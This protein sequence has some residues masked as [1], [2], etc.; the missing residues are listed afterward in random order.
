LKEFGRERAYYDFENMH[1]MTRYH[2]RIAAGYKTTM[3]VYQGKVLLCAEVAHKLFNI[4]S[5]YEVMQRMHREHPS[6][7]YRAACTGYLVGQTVMTMYNK[8]TYKIDDIAWAETPCDTFE[9]R[10]RR[11]ETEPGR[12]SFNDYYFEN[13]K[14]RIRD[15][16]QPLLISNPKARDKRGGVGSP[17]RLVPELCALTGTILLKDFARDFA[18]K[19][20]LDSITK[21]SP[22][23]RLVLI[24][25]VNP[26]FE[27]L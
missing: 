7:N 20:D 22:E 16:K 8:R 17:I 25:V 13:Y 1:E 24:R 9:T 11:G 4:N 14:I 21:L 27:L 18:M 23:V 15:G 3:S 19:K 10:P 26:S 2:L 6:E 12:V 5:V